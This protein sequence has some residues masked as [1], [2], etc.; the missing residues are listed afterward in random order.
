MRFKII[1]VVALSISAL[2]VYAQTVLKTVER[3]GKKYY[4]YKVG[5]DESLYGIAME[6][7]WDQSVLEAENPKAV[8]SLRK[9][10]L[11]YYPAATVADQ[12]RAAAA[13]SEERTGK[14]TFEVQN[15]TSAYELARLLGVTTE[16]LYAQNP[17][18]RHGVKK[19]D[20][21][22]IDYSRLNE[23]PDKNVGASVADKFSRP[24]ESQSGPKNESVS[25][26]EPTKEVGQTETSA[27][28]TVSR[29]PKAET[30]EA[31][32]PFSG[33]STRNPLIGLD[34][35][36]IMEYTV[37]PGDNLLSVA[38][39]F[40]TTVRDIFFLNPALSP[41][42]FPEGV[43]IRLLPGSK[44]ADRRVE[45]VKHREKTSTLKY[46]I[47]KDDT[48]QSVADAN[49]VTTEEIKAENPKLKEFG[50][51]KKIDI[52]QFTERIERIEGVFTD[53]RE[54]TREGQT[55]IWR[56]VR[57]FG[58]PAKQSC[59]LIDV[60]VLTSTASSDA[61]RER[62]FL[63]G[64]LLGVES[65]RAGDRKIGVQVVDATE[66]YFTAEANIKETRPEL[67][68]ATCDK[69]FPA[70]LVEYSD[71]KGCNIVNVFDAK[72]ED[73]TDSPY[74]FQVLM[75]TVMMNGKIASD[76]WNRFD[77]KEFIFVGEG[78][79]DPDSYAAILKKSLKDSGKKFRTFNSVSGIR[80]L[81]LF[82]SKGVT[83][84]SN[85]SSASEIRNILQAVASLRES[86]PNLQISLI[87]R[88]TWIVYADKMGDEMKNANTFIPS[89][90]F[91]DSDS[92]KWDAFREAFKEAY[93]TVPIA[94]FPPYAAMGY[95]VARY[96][97]NSLLQNGGDFN[98][99]VAN[100]KG[101]EMDFHFTR[102]SSVSG[103]VNDTLFYMHY[104]PSGV[105]GI[106]F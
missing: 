31:S 46:K 80:N 49:G 72:S 77:A 70:S 90:F 84:V 104:S 30:A 55:E 68:I 45:T 64:F 1:S 53:P 24:A 89:R 48:L 26:A 23:T 9:G 27:V 76:L 98:I 96:F 12:P 67:V 42:W 63:R 83:V 43:N 54:S 2:G 78:A 50:K 99:P 37:Q 82:E 35:D 34:N 15:S 19:G 47:K 38:N 61:K 33:A 7:G 94:S 41:D 87:G 88:P 59:N 74:M 101:V 106:S 11:L 39:N 91:Y 36:L 69:D 21:L 18:A 5:S 62:E 100:D 105:E 66:G 73:Y 65:L 86:Y 29:V 25:P 103:Y 102:T 17:S 58:K 97:I 32:K 93:N 22:S 51:G 95:D 60:A 20:V 57:D 16:Q 71:D 81:E 92:P 85:A 79:D 8:V 4:E 40:N 44:D 14:V 13:P 6:M 28:P 75:P 3:D 56:E 10:T 52:P